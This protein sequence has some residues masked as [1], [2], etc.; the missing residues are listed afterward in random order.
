MTDAAL[1]FPAP[2]AHDHAVADERPST[3]RFIFFDGFVADVTAYSEMPA[4][5]TAANR[6]GKEHGDI[7]PMRQAITVPTP[8]EPW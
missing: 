7:V 1:P 2:P 8:E 3:Y 6:W 5:F 4:R